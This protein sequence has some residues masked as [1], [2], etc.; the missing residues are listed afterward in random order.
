MFSLVLLQDRFQHVFDTVFG[1]IFLPSWLPNPFQNASKN[2]SK[3]TY[4]LGSIFYTFLAVFGPSWRHLGSNLAP[5]LANLAPF[6]A[7]R[8]RP[9]SAKTAISRFFVPRWPPRAPRPLRTSIFVKFGGPFLIFFYDFSKDSFTTSVF[10]LKAFGR[11]LRDFSLELFSRRSRR[12]GGGG[13]RPQGV[14]D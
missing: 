2:L 5:T 11:F 10:N 14:F 7:S 13:T 8:G 6:W 12:E 1:S 4:I 9:K 3:K